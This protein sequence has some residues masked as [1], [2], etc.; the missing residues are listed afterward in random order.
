MNENT[1]VRS[2]FFLLP[3][4]SIQSAAGYTAATERTDI[5]PDL[6][7]HGTHIIDFVVYLW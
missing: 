6:L 7:L 3:H 2:V 4:P 1:S 5:W